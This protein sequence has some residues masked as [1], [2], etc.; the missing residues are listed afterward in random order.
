[1]ERQAVLDVEGIDRLYLDRYQ[2]MLQSGGGVAAFFRGHRQAQVVSTSL[3][4]PTSRPSSRSRFLPSA[5]D[6]SLT[7]AKRSTDKVAPRRHA[8]QLFQ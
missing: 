7:R 4:G 1:V 6:S 2:P 3:M 8:Y 5:G